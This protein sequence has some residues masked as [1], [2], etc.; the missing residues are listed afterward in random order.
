MIQ[1]FTG[2]I[3]HWGVFVTADE[4]AQYGVD[5]ILKTFPFGTAGE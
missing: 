5:E 4:L 1:D 2:F 3:Q